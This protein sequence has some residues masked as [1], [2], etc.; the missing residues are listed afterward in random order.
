MIILLLYDLFPTSS[1]YQIITG[2]FPNIVR[3]YLISLSTLY[4]PT[5]AGKKMYSNYHFVT[6][7]QH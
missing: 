7:I 2:F 4:Y 1:Y 3:V 5:P 6:F